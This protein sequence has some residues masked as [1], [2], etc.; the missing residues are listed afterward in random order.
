M[1]MM[2]KRKTPLGP[3]FKHL[4][5]SSFKVLCSFLFENVEG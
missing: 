5:I 3:I 4:R 1:L 2:R